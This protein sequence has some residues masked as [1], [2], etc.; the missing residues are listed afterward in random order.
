MIAIVNSD[1][2]LLF[3]RQAALEVVVGKDIGDYAYWF[4][5]LPDVRSLR[6]N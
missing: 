5:T 4:H 6:R 3:F 1:V 2:P